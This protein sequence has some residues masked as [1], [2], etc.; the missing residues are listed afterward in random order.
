MTTL[1]KPTRFD[2]VHDPDPRHFELCGQCNVASVASDFTRQR[3]T[4]DEMD[5]LLIGWGYDTSQG[6]SF[7]MLE[8]LLSHFGIAW[9][10]ANG[11]LA[12][13]AAVALSRRHRLIWLF[14]TDHQANP[15]PR[16]GS[17]DHWMTVYGND[18]GYAVMQPW[19]GSDE[20]YG[21]DLLNQSDATQGGIEINVELPADQ[22]ADTM[23]NLEE[24]RVMVREAY[25]AS[26]GREPESTQALDNWA[27][28]I[29]DDGSNADD[30]IAQIT[31][32]PE[33]R[34]HRGESS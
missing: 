6:T 11:N 19:G 20:V 31:D 29:H 22:E 16:P 21:T 34:K 27:N 25:L 33:A 14:A 3:H 9:V 8:R 4:P 32:S 18:G 13:A 24:K 2:Q 10:R 30:V 12:D 15:V 26:M 23:L 17:T 5:Q 7:Q 28:Q 1:T